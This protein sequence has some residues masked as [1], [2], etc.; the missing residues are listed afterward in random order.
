MGDS[1]A[2]LRASRRCDGQVIDT[3]NLGEHNQRSRWSVSIYF[4]LQTNVMM[5]QPK[6]ALL[7]SYL[8]LIKPDHLA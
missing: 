5:I 7:A 1:D 4:R 2:I 8:E 6:L 3:I